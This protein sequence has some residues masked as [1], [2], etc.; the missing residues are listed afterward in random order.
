MY[1]H[2]DVISQPAQNRNVSL[3]PGTQAF[4]F[5]NSLLSSGDFV[6]SCK[7]TPIG[8]AISV[9]NDSTTAKGKG[10]VVPVLN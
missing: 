10:K 4:S 7:S 3:H 2:T 6:L 9:R 1:L 8:L 5:P